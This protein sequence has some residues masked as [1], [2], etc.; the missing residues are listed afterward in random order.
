M[1][2]VE[3]GKVTKLNGKR[4]WYEH[5]RVA[6]TNIINNLRLDWVAYVRTFRGSE[7][8][9]AV[10]RPSHGIADS[11]NHVHNPEMTL[12]SAALLALIGTVLI[13]GYLTWTLVF[14]VLY[15]LRGIAAP[16][17]LFASF[18]YAFACFCVAV[19]FFVFYRS[20]A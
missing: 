3:N 15:V 18:I 12:K 11:A 6:T 13:A 20:Q 2:N 16:V 10:A 17:T 8:S 4:L 19:F 5:Q 1:P 9:E 7:A 14:D